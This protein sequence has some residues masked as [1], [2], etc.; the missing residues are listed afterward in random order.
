MRKGITSS[1]DAIDGKRQHTQPCHDCPMRR[2]SLPG[3]LGDSTAEQYR[4]LCHSDHV[5]P[6]HAI[7]GTHCAGVAIYRTNVVKSAMFRLPADRETVFATPME[8]VEW[9]ENREAS[10]AKL[11]TMRVEEK[12]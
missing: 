3:W 12:I 8:F 7:R 11:K 5:V 1:D 10:F 4:T 6:C 2:N 9:H